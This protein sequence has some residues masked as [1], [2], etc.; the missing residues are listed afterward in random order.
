MRHHAEGFGK[1]QNH[2]M[3]WYSFINEC[4]CKYRELHRYLYY[5]TDDFESHADDKLRECQCQLL[6]ADEE[7]DYVK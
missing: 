5:K 7:E 3:G 6:I 4:S 2:Y 1:V